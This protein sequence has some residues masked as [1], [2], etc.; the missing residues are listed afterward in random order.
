MNE[1]T[2]RKHLILGTAGHI[3]HGKTALVKA[4][5]GIECDTHKEEK[6]RGI[7]I[8]LGFAHLT[9]SSG[10]PVGIVDVPGHAAF[11]RTM[12]SGASGIDF[13]LLVVAADEGVM[14]QTREHL[15]ILDILGVRAGLIAITKTDLVDSDVAEMAVLEVSELTKGTLLDGSPVVPVSAKSGEGLD[16]LRAEIETVARSVA[17]RPLGEVF[18]LYVDRSFAV[19]G[20]GTVVTGSVLGGSLHQGDTAYLLPGGD[21]ARVRRLERYGEETDTVTAGDR[22][23]INLAGVDTQRFGRGVLVS[24]RLLRGTRLLDGRLKVFAHARGFGL[25][26]RVTLHLGTYESQARMHLI[27]T[28]SVAG[29]QDALVQFELPQDCIAQAGDRFVIRSTSSDITLGGGEILDAFPLHHRRRPTALV[30]RMQRLA[31]GKGPAL[32]AAE[33]E[34]RMVP[35]KDSELADIMNM[36]TGD[37]HALL[38]QGP[39][40]NVGT[41]TR[42]DTVYFFRADLPSEWRRRLIA[43]LDSLHKRNPLDPSGMTL[44]QALGAVGLPPDPAA[45]AVLEPLLD[46]LVEKGELKRVGH[47]WARSSHT[48]EV[49]PELQRRI[50][51]VEQYLLDSGMKTPLLADLTSRAAAEGIDESSLHQVLRHLVRAGKAYQIDGQYLHASVVDSARQKLLAA[52]RERPEGLTVAGFRDLVQGNRKICL[53]MLSQFDAEGTTRR[54]GDRRVQGS[55]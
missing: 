14:P 33:V 50:A 8:H 38:A 19:K 44:G 47:T 39:P 46:D 20:F 24:D 42:D 1:Q 12:V 54:E 21:E 28:D 55:S 31:R 41:V 32:L 25:W 53:L 10:E 30:D 17:Q 23:S 11:V 22:A 13:C 18:R 34:K 36:S 26:S 2:S 5:T 27:D 6:Q 29:G 45:E 4:L 3:D 43:S 37:V 52:L 48:T 51:F 15:Q 7:T 9:L 35:L 40:P 49:S 16:R